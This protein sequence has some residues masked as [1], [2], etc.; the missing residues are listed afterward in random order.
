MRSKADMHPYQSRTATALYEADAVQ[1]ILPMGAGKTVS[2]ATAIRELIDDGHIKAAIINAPKRVARQT[3]P[4]EFAGW[5]HLK[6][7][8][9][10]LVLGDPAARLKA[11]HEPAEVY[12][13]SRDGGFT[14]VW[15]HWPT[16]VM[17]RNATNSRPR[18]LIVSACFSCT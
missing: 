7:T 2:A 10:S 15:K 1:A 13:T 14:P 4:D 9:L 3:W 16:S 12:I 5:E 8:K 17:I 18:W 6:D 11:L